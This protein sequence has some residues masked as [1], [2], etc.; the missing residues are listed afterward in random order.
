MESFLLLR[1][2]TTVRQFAALCCAGTLAWEYNRDYTN[3]PKSFSCW[4]LIIHF[5]YFQ[6]PLKSRA[7]SLIHSISFIGANIIPVLYAYLLFWNPILEISHMEEWDIAWNTVVTRSFFI[8][9]APLIF[10]VLDITS[11]QDNLIFSYKTKPK[12]FIMIWSMIALPLM[13][14][15]YEFAFP[16]SDEVSSLIG[17]KADDFFTIN[18]LI[19]MIV[20]GF[21]YTILYLLIFRKSYRSSNHVH[22]K[23]K[24]N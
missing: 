5:I 21:A 8:N 16:E 9:I 18:K 11:N 4:I 6:L 14:I 15:V 7:L 23:P 13:G 17:I 12:K 24:N 3:I 1:S 10:H 22:K 2:H 19:S 20:L